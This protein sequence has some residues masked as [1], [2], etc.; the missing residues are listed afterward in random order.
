MWQS[1]WYRVVICFKSKDTEQIATHIESYSNDSIC[2]YEHISYC[3]FRKIK[4]FPGK[5]NTHTWFLE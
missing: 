4:W 1:V 2:A 3:W 5:K